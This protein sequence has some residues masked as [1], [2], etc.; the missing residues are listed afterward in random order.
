MITAIRIIVM[1]I[2]IIIMLPKQ[3]S[4]RH[5]KKSVLCYYN[6]FT[7]NTIFLIILWSRI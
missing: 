3:N 5:T 4:Y 1:V 7:G 2:I 6:L